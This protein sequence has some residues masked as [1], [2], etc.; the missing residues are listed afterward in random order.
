MRYYACPMIGTTPPELPQSDHAP[1]NPVEE[2]ASR[3]AQLLWRQIE[4]ESQS[5]RKAA[6]KPH[7]MIQNG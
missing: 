5:R 4:D 7:G 3:L 1:E 6:S 2:F